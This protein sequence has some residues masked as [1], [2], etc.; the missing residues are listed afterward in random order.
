MKIALAVVAIGETYIEI[1]N[2]FFRES[3]ENYA[4]KCGYDFKLQ[5]DILDKH[6]FYNGI[7]WNKIL[8]LKKDWAS[9]YDFVIIIDADILININS[10]PIHL[11]TD[12]GDKVGIADEYEQCYSNLDSIKNGLSWG[13]D[14]SDYYLMSGFELDTQK[15]L[16]TGVLV[17][18]PSKHSAFFANIFEK[19]KIDASNHFR[20][21]HYE[22]SAIG[23]ELQND[24]MFVL[25]NSKFNAIWSIQNIINLRNP[26]FSLIRTKN[27]IFISQIMEY[28][29]S[30]Y[31]IHFAGFKNFESVPILQ[32]YNV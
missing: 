6:A 10:P 24:K 4:K 7:S 29:K 27:E 13:K 9:D 15:M 12:F 3:H 21:F 30:N 32:K 2:K 16:N 11:S 17:T 22:Q 28:F 19:Y 8:I 5:T 31:F 18:Q 1:Y 25:L 20:K 14:A 26:V 23:Y